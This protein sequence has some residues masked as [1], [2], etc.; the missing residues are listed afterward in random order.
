MS[1]IIIKQY[2]LLEMAVYK[3]LSIKLGN[4]TYPIVNSLIYILDD[5]LVDINDQL[6]LPERIDVIESIL[7]GSIQDVSHF[8][9]VYTTAVELSNTSCR[10]GTPHTIMFSLCEGLQLLCE[11]LFSTTPLRPPLTRRVTITKLVVTVQMG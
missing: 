3:Q 11:E 2:D 1:V 10:G 7:H 9:D 5:I 8:C 6:I 4:W